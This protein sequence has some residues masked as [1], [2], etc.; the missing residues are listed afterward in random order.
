MPEKSR[1]YS[2]VP[3]EE[4]LN[5]SE[6]HLSIDTLSAYHRR[7]LASEENAKVRAH[8]VLCSSCRAL[9]LDL[10]RFLDDPGDPGRLPV[11]DI[12]AAWQQLQKTHLKTGIR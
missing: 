12:V 8:V 11:E 7:V 10:A 4:A 3:H 1:A 5:N 2:S 6:G 9:L